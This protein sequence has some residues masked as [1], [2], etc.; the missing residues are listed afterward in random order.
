MPFR[1]EA[2]FA[3]EGDCLILHY[4]TEANPQIL[5]IDGGSSGVYRRSLR[6][7]LQQLRDQLGQRVPLQMVMV[8]HVDADHI[9]GILDLFEEL[10]ESNDPVCEV[11]TLWHNSFDDIIGNEDDELTSAVIA[12]IQRD[13]VVFTADSD[14]MAVAASIRQGRNLRGL[15][16]T[17]GIE[18]NRHF[19]GLIVANEQNTRP[20]EIGGGMTFTVLGPSEQRIEA[21][22]EEWNDFLEEEELAEA[23]AAALE[24]D[25][26]PNLSSIMVLAQQN[27]RTMQLTGDARGDYIV[28]GL[29]TAGLLPPEAELPILFRG[30]PNALRQERRAA[31]AVAEAL[32]DPPSVHFDLL[33]MPHHGSNHNVSVGFF[34]RVTADHY[35]ISADGNHDNP[36]VP[37]LEMLAEA[38]GDAPYTIHLTFTEDRHLDPDVS[39]KFREALRLVHNWVTNDKPPNCTVFYSQDD[40]GITLD[41][42]EPGP[43]VDEDGQDD[44]GLVNIN[45]ADAAELDTLPRIGPS[46]AGRIIAARPFEDGEHL[47]RVRGIGARTLARLRPLI[48]V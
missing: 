34:R 30:M 7:R 5:L 21:L 47:T 17:L 10:E 43:V 18:F 15:A 6:P 48:T 11:G 23:V 31:L 33:K 14:T 29:I 24:D 8:S 19:T 16:E 42:S 32:E 22:R 12:S 1:I 40:F 45:T 46:L 4:G 27:R 44:D 2:L 20:I 38:R 9:R 13:E 26:I 41:L 3:R 28:E 39:A 36:D 35:I 25:S 37:T